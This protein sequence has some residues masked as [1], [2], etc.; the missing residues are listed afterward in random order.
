[1]AE[2]GPFQDLA[3]EQV[4]LAGGVGGPVGPHQDHLLGPDA[5]HH[6]G[7]RRKPGVGGEEELPGH[8][9]DPEPLV[10]V[11][12]HGPGRAR[13]QVLEHQEPGHPQVGRPVVEFGRP[14]GL[15]DAAGHQ[16]GHA[17]GHEEG[18]L[19]VVGHLD[20]GDPDPALEVPELGLEPAAK[21]GVEGRERLVQKEHPG[22]GHEGPGQGHPLALPAREGAHVPAP[23]HPSQVQ[24]FHP[25]PEFP[26]GL[27]PGPAPGPEPEQDVL[28]DGEV[29]KEGEVLGH[30]GHAP[31]LGRKPGD[32]PAVQ[33]DPAGLGPADAQ[34]RLQ[35]QGLPGPGGAQ[36]EEALPGFHREVHGLEP[37]PVEPHGEPLGPDHRQPPTSR[38]TTSTPRLRAESRRINATAPVM[39]ASASRR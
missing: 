39:S 21:G 17:V 15:L 5:H 36:H 14:A 29:G 22:L 10:P 37:E 16:D 34:E 8:P 28:P 18:L 24:Q 31:G 9:L 35:K 26:V 1:M 2:V 19:G 20:H 27:G 38:S 11:V 12:A 32:V 4:P 25:A 23:H 7:A 13:K 3:E 30:V 6:P 33:H